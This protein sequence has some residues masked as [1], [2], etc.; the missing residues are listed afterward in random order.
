M[1]GTT[2]TGRRRPARRGE[3]ERLRDEIVE[4]A[5]ALIAAGADARTL[6]LRAVAREVGVA[7]TSIYLH[8]RDLDALLVAVKTRWF[9]A[10]TETLAAA[11]DAAGADPYERTR[12]AAH[13]YVRFGTTH[14]GPYRVLFTSPITL[15][16][17]PGAAFIGEPTFRVVRSH[18]EAVVGP[19]EDA[20][21]LTVHFWTA[22]HGLVTLR[23]ARANFPWPELDVEVDD[24]VARLLRPG[25]PP[26]R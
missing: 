16:P 26:S 6:S 4:A 11:A 10:L 20:W 14:A 25:P 17:P 19:G 1:V 2:A 5:S 24:L 23:A 7:T 12:A 8:F 18:V 9:G 13:A 22:M 21:M 3:G 15:P